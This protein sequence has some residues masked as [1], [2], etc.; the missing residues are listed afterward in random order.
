[1][2]CRDTCQPAAPPGATTNM[3]EVSPRT[4]THRH[5]ARSQTRLN[6][7]RTATVH[8]TH[9]TQKPHTQQ[10][11]QHTATHTCHTRKQGWQSAYQTTMALSAPTPR[12][13]QIGAHEHTHRATHTS[14]QPSNTHTHTEQCHHGKDTDQHTTHTQCQFH[15]HKQRGTKQPPRR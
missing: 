14:T 6:G 5:A 2:G 7:T 12:G 11:E 15:A 13:R 8:N 9:Q 1:M 4:T 3:N 10:P